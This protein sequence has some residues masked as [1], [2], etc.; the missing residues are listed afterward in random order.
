MS[1]DRKRQSAT[2]DFQR[3]PP[4]SPRRAAAPAPARALQRR[5]GNQGTQRF[6]ARKFEFVRPQPIPQD[7]IPLALSRPTLGNTRPG[8]NDAL[9]PQ[10]ATKL[11]Y[12]EAVFNALQPQTF[13][14]SDKNGAKTVRVDA[15]KFVLKVFAE[16]NV[17]TRPNGAM[18]SGT[19]DRGI[20]PNAACTGG[21]QAKTVQVDMEGKPDSMAL[22]NKVQAHEQEHVTDLDRISKAKLKAYHDFLVG[23]AGRGKTEQECVQDIFKQVGKRDALAA[24]EFVDTWLEAVQVYDKPTGTHHSKFETRLDRDCT[25]AHIKEK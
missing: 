6:I 23:L 7:P 10:T 4:A 12:K 17:V 5:L 22:Y 9:L 3:Q 11:A 15:D 18:W 19:Y 14:P 1:F 13:A 20:L 25:T 21:G 8:L 24:N 16:V 2:P